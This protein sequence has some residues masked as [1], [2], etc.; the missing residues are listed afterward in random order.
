M[1]SISE[2]NRGGFTKAAP[3][4]PA[5]PPPGG[6]QNKSDKAAPK[7]WMSKHTTLVFLIAV[8]LL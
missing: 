1:Y 3:A 5:A 6:G 2:L 8:M 7:V 4:A